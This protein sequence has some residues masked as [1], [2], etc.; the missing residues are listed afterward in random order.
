MIYLASPYWHADLAIRNQRFRAACGAT[1][2]M[3]REGTTVFS[4]VVT[5]MRWS[6]K[7]CPATGRSG[8][9]KGVFD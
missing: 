8:R 5:A 7:G 3:I 1:A 6:G 4:P 9:A 2:Q